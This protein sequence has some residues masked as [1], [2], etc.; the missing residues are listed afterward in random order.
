MISPGGKPATGPL[1]K[2]GDST[3]NDKVTGKV[4]LNWASL[5]KGGAFNNFGGSWHLVGT[6]KR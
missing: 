6:L 5:I 2:N 3:C 1:V 4:V